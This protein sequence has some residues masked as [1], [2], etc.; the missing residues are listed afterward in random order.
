MNDLKT[1]VGKNQYAHETGSFE[2]TL[3]GHCI[4]TSGS[5]ADENWY[6][7]LLAQHLPACGYWTLM[8]GQFGSSLG[9]VTYPSWAPPLN[10]VGAS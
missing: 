9:G 7:E 3:N 4:A 1:L 2:R 5:S 10:C 8:T 6:S